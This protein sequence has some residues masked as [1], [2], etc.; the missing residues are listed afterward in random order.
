M[1]TVTS[2]VRSRMMSTIRSSNTKPELRVRRYLHERGFRYRLNC[3]DL[4]G[5]PDLVLRR[6]NAVVLVHGC[7]WHGHGGCPY[8]TTPATR[9][10]FW[11]QKIGA[12][13][14]RDGR[15]V[16]QLKALD[17]RVAVIWECALRKVPESALRKL[18]RFLISTRTTIEIAWSDQPNSE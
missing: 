4:P 8:A 13:K 12:N 14:A 9:T 6:R 16:S 18:E 2:E 1:D 11:L 5:K 7:F 10:E 3:K 15:V 17:W